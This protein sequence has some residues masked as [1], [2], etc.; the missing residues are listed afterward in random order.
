MM[1]FSEN[2]VNEIELLKQREE[3]IK[4]IDESDLTPKKDKEL[5]KQ[6][7]DLDS[8]LTVTD[9]ELITA[10]LSRRT[11]RPL[12]EPYLLELAIQQFPGNVQIDFG[13][14]YY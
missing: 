8:L 7:E 3:L 13:T 14:I 11:I 4:E 6:V 10:R 12:Y 2:L 9:R 1:A 5:R